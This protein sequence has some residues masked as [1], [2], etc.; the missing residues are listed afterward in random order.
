M[1]KLVGFIFM[2]TVAMLLVQG[3]G[4]VDDAV[5]KL[6]TRTEDVAVDLAPITLTGPVVAREVFAT[7]AACPGAPTSLDTLLAAV[8]GWEDLSPHLQDISIRGVAYTISNNT[9]PVDV[10]LSLQVS[11]PVTEELVLVASTVETG[12]T[13]QANT[14]IPT[15]TSLPFVDGGAAVVQYYL[16]NRAAEFTY[17]AEIDPDDPDLS[18]T[19]TFRLNTEVTV[20]L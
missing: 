9:T 20:K 14:S 13:I 17:C 3:C 7:V 16:N 6:T 8:S 15:W 12:T 18:L 1:R 19:V 11:D 10:D 4:A 5:D 2:A